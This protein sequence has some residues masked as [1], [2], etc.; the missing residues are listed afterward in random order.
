MS[1]SADTF[2]VDSHCHL[3]YNGLHDNLEDIFRNAEARNVKAFLAI[4]TR[5]SEFDEVHK[6]ALDHDNVWST[7]G[8]HPHEAENETAAK[9]ALL[10]RAALDKV[11][12]IGETGLDYF[13]DN[14]PKDAQK[15][16]FTVHIE[17][18]AEAGLPLVVHSREA[19]KDT[20]NLLK[21]R[22][23]DI[24]GVMHCFTASDDLARKALDLGLYISISG[25]VTFRNADN[26]REVAKFVPDDRLLVET[27]SPYLAPVPHRGK[28]CQ[29]AY[30]AD[31]L[32]FLAELRGVTP[33]KLAGITTDN[34][35]TLFTKA[36][37]P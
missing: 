29:P 12:A 16:N 13:Y 7:V 17:A 27:D 25:I 1:A 4:N 20:H 26:V 30:T 2:I 35:F 33:E 3:N 32:E 6:I 21:E 18:A 31:T 9:A 37:R 8:I 23:G 15:Q 10:E 11:I 22:A 14:A 5:I 28:P 34:F 36:Q 19:E 24:T